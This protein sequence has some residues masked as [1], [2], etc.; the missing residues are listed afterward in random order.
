[1]WEGR[2]EVCIEV[3]CFFFLFSGSTLG[4]EKG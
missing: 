2:G 1:M 3:G 4:M